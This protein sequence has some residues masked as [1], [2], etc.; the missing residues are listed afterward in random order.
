MILLEYDVR[1]SNG[2]ATPHHMDGFPSVETAETY[3]YTAK[4][5]IEKNGGQTGEPCYTVYS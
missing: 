4:Y 1:D 5:A 3:Y 2:N